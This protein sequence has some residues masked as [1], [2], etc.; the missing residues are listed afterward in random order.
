MSSIISFFVDSFYVNLD[1][2]LFFE[3][4]N[5]SIFKK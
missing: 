1:I 3:L 4:I 2:V 5:L